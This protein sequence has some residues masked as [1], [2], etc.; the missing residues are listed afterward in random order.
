MTHYRPHLDWIKE[1]HH[2]MVELLKRWSNINSWSDNISG[3]NE[4]LSTLQSTFAS[5]GGKMETINV[6]SR[7]IVDS[8]GHVFEKEQG[9]VLHITKHPNAP[10]KVFLGGHMDTVYSHTSHYQTIHQLDENTLCG[11]GV[12]DM[13]G[14]L[15]VMFKIL[16]CIERSP[17]AGKIGWEV[18]INSDEETGSS[19]SEPLFAQCAKRNQVG[20][21]FEPSFPDGAI[22]SSRKGSM[23]F[24]VIARGKSA[25]A[26][27]DFHHGRNAISAMA[28]F[29]IE[30]ESL[31]DSAKGITVNVG[32]I[33]GGGPV[34]IVPD[35]AI[36]RF[37]VRMVE[38][39]DLPLLKEM[40]HRIAAADR[41]PEGISYTYIDNSM[42]GPKP[43]DDAHRHLFETMKS[44]GKD[45][46]MSLEWKPSGGVCD[47]N[48]LSFEGLP[49]IDTLGV[50]GGNIHTSDEYML[51]SSLTERATLTAYF[52]MKLANRE[53]T[54]EP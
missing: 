16:E 23:N 3:L 42:R 34:N 15:V 45:L 7:L 25:H 1:Q 37:N 28:R 27:R 30:A 39:S 6:P 32:N 54:L 38:P 13:K 20:L 52:L 9:K 22:V 35:L 8:K 41:S 4:M 24:T 5:L 31:T 43:F 10:I 44:C 12:A 2:S 50:I 51:L 33:E 18:L 29:I 11:P 47:G 21:L 36:S 46:G 40:L 19:G 17:F 53:I 48:T 14:G 49:T 26:G